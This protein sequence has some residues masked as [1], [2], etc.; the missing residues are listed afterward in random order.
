MFDSQLNN[1][2]KVGI[3]EIKMNSNQ[4]PDR[5]MQ[6][7]VDTLH[8]IPIGQVDLVILPE[9]WI[10]GAFDYAANA[11]FN[12]SK[13]ALFLQECAII[14]ALKGFYLHS[15]SH[16][17][18]DESK[19]LFNTAVVFDN[20]G[21]LVC[22]Y[23]KIHLFGFQKG[24]KSIFQAGNK[25]GIFSLNGILAGVSTCYDLRFPELYV[26]QVR[27]GA[28]ILL[29]SA[30][31]RTKT[32]K[33]WKHLMVARAIESQA[34]VVGCNASGISAGVKLGSSSLAIDPHGTELELVS[35]YGLLIASLNISDLQKYRLEF[36]VIKDKRDC[37][38][39]KT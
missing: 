29:V 32:I 26:A 35:K 23:E 5:R 36:P 24:E 30:A 37:F 3:F 16:P 10:L 31:W 12:Q 7:V 6:Q 21:N 19:C 1:T 13:V 15:G 34:F 18:R 20:D 2:V 9:L 22:S 14:S 39:F 11:N 8:R 17:I 33:Q 38:V 27:K 28:Q 25:I 4:S